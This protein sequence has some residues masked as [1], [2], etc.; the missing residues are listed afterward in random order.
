MSLDDV[1]MGLDN[2]ETVES[3]I[4][5]VGFDSG[6]ASFHLNNMTAYPN[7]VSQLVLGGYINSRSYSIWLDD[8]DAA[9]GS[10]IFSGID[11]LKYSGDLLVLPI[12][13]PPAPFVD[14]PRTAVQLTALTFEDAEGSHDLVP[15]GLNIRV[16]LDTGASFCVLPKSVAG[17]MYAAA[18]VVADAAPLVGPAASCNLT[19][20]P[21]SFTFGFGC[22]DGAKIRVPMGEL[23]V[24]AWN[25]GWRPLG[26]TSACFFGITFTDDP[27]TMILG[28]TFLRSAYVVYDLDNKQIGIAQADNAAG[29]ATPPQIQEITN[30]TAGMPGARKTATMIPWPTSYVREWSLF[31]SSL[32]AHKASMTIEATATVVPAA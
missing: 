26:T 2:S 13:D 22:P 30:G 9:S 17:A 8:H 4:L 27:R 15:E 11:T 16:T 28:D 20:A 23:I 21:E 24:P 6:E 7:L 25:T 32:S 29:I 5:G 1:Q 31:A 18:G 10:L 3:G 19:A 14:Y 12:V